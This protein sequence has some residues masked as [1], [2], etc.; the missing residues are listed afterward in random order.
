[1]SKIEIMGKN[2]RRK[3][4]STINMSSRE[5]TLRDLVQIAEGANEV[6]SGASPFERPSRLREMAKENG[7]KIDQGALVPDSVMET[8]VEEMRRGQDRENSLG[9]MK[10]ENYI[11]D[12]I[13][14]MD[15]KPYLKE[16]E[17]RIEGGRVL[18]IF[19]YL[20]SCL[21][22]IEDKDIGT[23]INTDIITTPMSASEIEERNLELDKIAKKRSLIFNSKT[24]QKWDD[25]KNDKLRRK[26]AHHLLEN[27]EAIFLRDFHFLGPYSDVALV[28]YEPE[29]S[30]FIHVLY[31]IDGINPET[32]NDDLNGMINTPEGLINLKWEDM[33]KNNII[34]K[35]HILFLE[36]EDIRNF[37]AFDSQW[38]A[39]EECYPIGPTIERFEELRTTHSELF[40]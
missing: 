12:D 25:E 26:L 28:V 32:L 38:R 9:F 1:M 10:L 31:N 7:F 15:W 17:K 5:D 23:E 37:K 27:G 2:N 19:H 4:I 14:H 8:L 40:L 22:S 39:L 29:E 21:L 34:A 13:I 35:H 3:T 6:F 24:T 33:D 20:A 18:L 11:M 30:S 16:L 36:G